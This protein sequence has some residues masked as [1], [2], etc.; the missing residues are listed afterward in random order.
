MH[1]EDEDLVALLA[2]NLDMYYERLVSIYWQQ[3][4]NFV[5]RQTGSMQD[6]EDIVQEAVVR[7]YLALERYSPQRIQHMK[8]RPWLYKLTWNAY[9][10]YMSR[11][12]PP[13]SVPLDLSEDGLHLEREESWQEQPEVVFENAERRR[14]LEALLCT[15]PLRYREIVNMYYFEELSHQ[16]IAEILNAPV[17]TIRVYLHRSMQMLRK[18]IALQTSEVGWNDAI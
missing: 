5:L 16:E 1:I 10:N 12:K 6:A 18:T 3:L 8:I 13:E 4:R 17:T 14:E 2:F 11:S 15:L 7:A 9:C